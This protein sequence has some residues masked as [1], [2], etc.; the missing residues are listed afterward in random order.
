MEVEFDESTEEAKTNSAD[1]YY[2]DAPTTDP[3]EEG[4]DWVQWKGGFRGY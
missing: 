4:Y 3:D 2:E 1:E